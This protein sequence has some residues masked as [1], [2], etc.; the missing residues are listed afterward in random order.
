MILKVSVI[1]YP[2]YLSQTPPKV[3]PKKRNPYKVFFYSGNVSGF[4]LSPENISIGDKS[5][6]DKE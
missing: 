6:L 2:Y 1:I 3:K 4:Q 5:S